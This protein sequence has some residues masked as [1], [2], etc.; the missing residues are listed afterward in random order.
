MDAASVIKRLR[1]ENAYLH[2]QN[3]DLR[4]RNG[5]LSTANEGLASLVADLK[6]QKVALVEKL[7]AVT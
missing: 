3:A 5:E 7:A 4:A 1:T 2:A 6:G